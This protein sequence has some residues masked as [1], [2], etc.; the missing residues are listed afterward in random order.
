MAQYFWFVWLVALNALLVLLLA[1]HVSRL[2]IV[3]KIPYGDGGD[4]D[5]N[6]AIRAHANAVEHVTIFALGVLALSL[7]NVQSQWLGGLV[8]AF[9]LARLCHAY[10]M[11][12]RRFNA[13][14]LGAAVTYLSELLAVWLLF[15]GLLLP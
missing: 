10:G 1:L 11:N 13:R 14:R 12:A 5:M 9:T 3:K 6:Q 2:R 8:V 7:M 4:I 15:A